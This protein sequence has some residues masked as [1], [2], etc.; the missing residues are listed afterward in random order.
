MPKLNPPLSIGDSDPELFRKLAIVKRYYLLAVAGICALTL[1]GWYLP[2]LGK[3]LPNGWRLMSAETA[4]GLLLSAFSL[5]FSEHRFSLRV[6]RLSRLFAVL[7][8]VLGM[9]I[10]GEYAFHIAA[11]LER[12][13]PFDP[14]STSLWPGRPSP[15]TA[16]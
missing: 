14:N 5:E 4:L 13:F 15:Q 2:V 16:S 8:A 3:F 11:G 6:K 7:A 12:L 10:L 1:L 9:A